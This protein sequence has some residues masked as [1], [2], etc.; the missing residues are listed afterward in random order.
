MARNS[1]NIYIAYDGDGAGIKAAIRN[2]Q[3]IE[4]QELN[5]YIVPMPDGE[6][7][8][9]YVLEHGLKAFNEL[10]KQKTLPIEF[11]L[12]NYVKLNPN[13]SLEEKDKFISEVLGELVSFKSA[14]KAGLYIHHLA[15]RMQ[16]SEAMLVGEINRLKQRQAR[17][18]KTKVKNDEPPDETNQNEQPIKRGAHKAE[19]GLLEL[20]LNANGE[21]QNY[22][23]E[24]VSINLFENDDYSGLYDHIIHDIEEFGTVDVQKLFENSALNENQH[25]ILT[26]LTINPVSNEMKHAV[27][28]IFQLKKWQL[29]KQERDIQNHIK[30]DNS[31]ESAMHYTFELAKLNKE[32]QKLNKEYLRDLKLYRSD[33]D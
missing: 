28:C 21:T 2:A 20:L 12:D 31:E 16:V 23:V 8:D 5:A 30:I 24:H 9:T 3:I 11:Q 10:L 19:E 33:D 29:E 6:D 17:Y 1:K 32:K 26:R 13:P 25:L 14:S 15:D 7:P 22:V 4:N 18:N 27:G